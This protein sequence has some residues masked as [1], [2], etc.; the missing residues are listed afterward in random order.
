VLDGIRPQPAADQ[1][2]G[3][4]GA[5]EW[6]GMSSVETATRLSLLRPSHSRETRRGH[7]QITPRYDP[8]GGGWASLLTPSP[9]GWFST[10]ASRSGRA[11][12]GACLPR[13]SG[14]S[15]CPPTPN[16]KKGPCVHHAIRLGQ[17][18]RH[19]WP[20]SCSTLKPTLHHPPIQREVIVGH[21]GLRM[22]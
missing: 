14:V 4:P 15:H 17:Q 12:W 13:S 9:C 8:A 21:Q 5:V 16:F 20:T 11:E 22:R 18:P 1:R 3:G 6:S 7:I 10:H 2:C 19:V